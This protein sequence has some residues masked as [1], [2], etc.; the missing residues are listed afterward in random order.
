MRVRMIVCVHAL[1]ARFPALRVWLCDVIEGEYISDTCACLSARVR[2]FVTT[3]LGTVGI[4]GMDWLFH[5]RRVRAPLQ[6]RHR[7]I[8]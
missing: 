8:F 3:R 5:S 2:A 7:G 6:T 4:L 1:R